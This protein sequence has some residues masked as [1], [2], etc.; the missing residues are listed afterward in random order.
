MGPMMSGM[1]GMY[2]NRMQVVDYQ[3]AGGGRYGSDRRAPLLSAQQWPIAVDGQP[4]GVLLVQGSMMGHT[5]FDSDRLVQGNRA[6][7]VAGTVAGLVA[8]LLAGLLVR[9]ITRPVGG[10]IAALRRIAGGGI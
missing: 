6:V 9:Q 1:M 5:T 4:I 7:V 3:W 8:L 10:L 2:E